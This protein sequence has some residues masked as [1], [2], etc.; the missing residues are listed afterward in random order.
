MNDLDKVKRN[1]GKNIRRVR[2]LRGIETIEEAAKL[3]DIDEKYYGDIERG[4]K[5]FTIEILIKIANGLDV[6]L[7]ELFIKDSNLLSLRFVISEHNI[8][9][10][11]EVVKM[12]KDLIES[13]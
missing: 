4:K 7:E 10:L 5:N 2:Q 3:I 1:L 6:S 13:K 11:K 9:T 8:T 12:I